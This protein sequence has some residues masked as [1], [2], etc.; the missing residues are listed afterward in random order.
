MST[1][2]KVGLVPRPL[3]NLSNR[4]TYSA[5][6]AIG[7][8]SI[9]TGNCGRVSELCFLVQYKIAMDG[10]IFTRYPIGQRSVGF[11]VVPVST[12]VQHFHQSA[13]PFGSKTA[14]VLV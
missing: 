8:H 9:R 1:A 13:V 10:N 6:V 3:K 14:S 11:C 2:Y 7:Q 5:R 12:S 4:A